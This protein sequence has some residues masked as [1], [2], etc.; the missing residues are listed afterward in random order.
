MRRVTT[1]VSQPLSNRD[2]L[3]TSRMVSVNAGAQLLGELHYLRLNYD[4]AMVAGNVVHLDAAGE[5]VPARV[6]IFR[7][8]QRLGCTE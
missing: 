1:D 7:G 4:I 5:L 3:L 8:V 2:G 6:W